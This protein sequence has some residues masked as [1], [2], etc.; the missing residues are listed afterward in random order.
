[1]G[2][3]K[4]IPIFLQE[5]KLSKIGNLETSNGVIRTVLADGEGGVI[6]ESK[7]D[8]TDFIEHNKAQY[9][10]NSGRT[11]W[12]GELYDP[13]NKIASIPTVIVDELNKKGIMRGYHVIDVPAFRRW[14]NDPDNVVFR[15]RGGI[16]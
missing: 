7:V 14:L 11:G 16:V 10:Q 2:V 9:N 12:S 3:E 6:V 5:R 4:S 1:M 8:L 15:T 13:K